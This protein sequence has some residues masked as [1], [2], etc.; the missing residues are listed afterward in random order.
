MKSGKWY[1]ERVEIM[2]NGV[3]DCREDGV[4]LEKMA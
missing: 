1:V 3:E 4:K 2:V